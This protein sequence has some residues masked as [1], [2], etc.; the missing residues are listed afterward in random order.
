MF[1]LIPSLL[2]ILQ[3]MLGLAFGL[4]QPE[5]VPYLPNKGGLL[6]AIANAGHGNAVADF[7]RT[8]WE[9]LLPSWGAGWVFPGRRHCRTANPVARMMPRLSWSHL[10][11]S[12]HADAHS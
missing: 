4:Q 8:H 5:P 11:L 7:L 6:R 10:F 2:A 3:D 1:S 9:Q 12:I